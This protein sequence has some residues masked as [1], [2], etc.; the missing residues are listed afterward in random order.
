MEVN[1]DTP[2]WIVRQFPNEEAL[3]RA[4]AAVTRISDNYKG[5]ENYS[6]LSG[7]A[8]EL[9]LSD[10]SQAAELAAWV[11]SSQ[12]K[13]SSSSSSSSSRRDNDKND[14]DIDCDGLIDL[15]CSESS[16]SD[17]EEENND[18]AAT[19]EDED[20]DEDGGYSP[21]RAVEDD[22]KVVDEYGYVR[23]KE[24]LARGARRGVASITR[25]RE[26]WWHSP[27]AEGKGIDAKWA[28]KW[29][30]R[31]ESSRSFKNLN[32]HHRQRR[33]GAAS[34]SPALLSSSGELSSSSSLGCGGNAGSESAGGGGNHL[35]NKNVRRHSSTPAL[36]SSSSSSSKDSDAL[37]QAIRQGVPPE[38]REE[39]WLQCLGARDKK[40][41]ALPQDQYE[42]VLG[43]AEQSS[44]YFEQIEKDLRR[45]LPTNTHFQREDGLD[46]LRSVLLAYSERNR[47]LG[48]CQSMNFVAAI[49]LLH[50]ECDDVFWC[51]AAIVEDILPQRWFDGDFHGSLVET[52]VLSSCVKW[53]LPKLHAHLESLQV[54]F[55][56]GTWPWFLSLFTA[57]L[58]L[59]PMLRAWDCFFHEGV[60]ALQRVA[61]GLLWLRQRDLLALHDDM[62]IFGLLRSPSVGTPSTMAAL[63]TEFGDNGDDGDNDDEDHD[64]LSFG[65][66]GCGCG[67]GGAQAE[68][69][70]NGQT[71]RFA[72]AFSADELFSAAYATRMDKS[73]P[74]PPSSSL[75]RG[76]VSGGGSGVRRSSVVLGLVSKLTTP[77]NLA[78]SKRRPKGGCG[79]HEGGG[80]VD[81][82]GG[83]KESPRKTSSLGRCGGGRVLSGGGGG[84]GSG[85]GGSLSRVL[86]GSSS[87]AS[88]SNRSAS[89]T[90]LVLFHQTP[91]EVGDGGGCGERRWRWRWW[92]HH[93]R[94]CER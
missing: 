70:E 75:N 66:G 77:T 71:S 92:H 41:S 73:P 60:K 12:D 39:V 9:D 15:E 55:E 56:Q 21:A 78:H 79:G 25:Q 8:S 64:E 24:D 38:L 37:T 6:C 17:E 76:G 28:Q 46:A 31:A 80:C 44:E 45:T 16:S 88:S 30:K 18:D 84:G 82:G 59:E 68:G 83:L 93:R 22:S 19:A 54:N 57:T 61:M 53:K 40:R 94:H 23:Q 51:L 11:R 91:P 34:S 85:S 29:Q 33:K 1:A 87:R 26:W 86:G 48:Y 35:H 42:A 36:S 50:M 3:D 5:T 27:W 58:P 43:R 72:T 67:E 63:G 74:P 49:L 69:A 89:R 10:E 47:A 7:I 32:N 62:E 4:V 52:R 14:A 13:P 90:R 2:N 65:G 20:G 81:G